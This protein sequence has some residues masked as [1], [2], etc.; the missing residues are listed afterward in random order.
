MQ[1]QDFF[2]SKRAIVSAFVPGVNLLLF[3]FGFL[4]TPKR[5]K[6]TLWSEIIVILVSASLYWY[7]HSFQWLFIY[8]TCTILALLELYQFRTVGF[9][10][11]KGVSFR[12]LL[13]LIPIVLMIV[14]PSLTPDRTEDYALVEKKTKDILISIVE[15]NI[16]QW[17][18][19]CHPKDNSRLDEL[20]WLDFWKLRQELSSTDSLPE[21]V[22]GDFEQVW[23]NSKD[24]IDTFTINAQYIVP[25]GEKTYRVTVK[26]I[27]DYRGQGIESIT[28]SPMG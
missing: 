6:K 15:D 19:A 24:M 2:R 28:I 20:N 23:L 9:V 10:F 4:L 22:I 8:I 11:D 17:K 7:V 16:T 1:V 12:F 18:A 21:G 26:Y 25:I 27:N 5:A 14:V 13:L 3:L